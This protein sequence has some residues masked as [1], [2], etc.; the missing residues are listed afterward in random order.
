ME[1]FRKSGGKFFQIMYLISDHKVGEL[2]HQIVIV[3]IIIISTSNIIPVL[4]SQ[5]QESRETSLLR[6]KEYVHVVL[7]LN[8][9]KQ[10]QFGL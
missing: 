1:N 7:D 3:I 5:L 2:I 8:S 4:L 10:T 9:T 6:D